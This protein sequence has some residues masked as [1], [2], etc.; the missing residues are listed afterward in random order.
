[1]Q[2]LSALG[3]ELFLEIG[4]GQQ[5][6]GLGRRCLPAGAEAWIPSAR[7]DRGGWEQILLS[8]AQLYV[9]GVAV[10]WSRV[11][12]GNARCK[13]P[14]PTYPFQRERHWISDQLAA[15][16]APG[17]LAPVVGSLLG[18]HI[19]DSS[20]HVFEAQISSDAPGLYA[21]HRVHGEV[22]VP[23][24]AYLELALAA[25]EQAFGPGAKLVEDVTIQAALV[26]D[27]GTR[28]IQVILTPL[29]AGASFEVISRRESGDH[30]PW[31]RHASGRVR[32]GGEAT[33]NP[34]LS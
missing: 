33:P 24:T 14:L 21:D 10:D 12:E 28:T 8:L 2:T 27:T 16:L 1:M 11:E 15:G 22:V 18:R 31:T 5:L 7:R 30:E 6:L 32:P 23:G 19:V 26:L 17:H 9:R 25:A 34:R 4:P 13:V 29:D 20:I 3:G